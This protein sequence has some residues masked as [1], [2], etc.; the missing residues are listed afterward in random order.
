MTT[1]KVQTGVCNVPNRTIFEGDNLDVMRGMNDGCVD[2]IYLDPPFNSNRDYAAPIGSEA[3]GAAFKDTWGLTDVDEAWHNEIAETDLALYKIID[4]SQH[5][6]GSGMKSYLIMMAVRLIEMKRILKPTGSVYLHCDGTASHY[7]KALMDAV[8]GR[9]NFRNEIIWK[10]FNF[11]ADARRFGKV[12]DSLLFYSKTEKYVFNR[13]KAPY[14]KDYIESKFTHVDDNGRRFRL[15]NLNP[16]GGRGPVYEF[17]GVTK[18]WRYTEEN[19]RA[20]ESE[21]RIYTKS[22]VAQLKRYLDELDGQA[23]HNMWTDVS[24]INPRAKERTGYP[25]QKPLAL[26]DRIIKASSNEG[27]VV[28]DPFCGCATTCI[29]AERLDRRWIGIDLSALAV[30]L[31]EQRARNEL[32]LMGGVQAIARSGIPLRTDRK[33]A[34]QLSESKVVLYGTQGGNC[35]GCGTHFLPQHLTVD[36]II[37][38]SKGGT[39]HL[40]NLQL[41]CGHCN[42]L[43]GNR[44]MEYLRARLARGYA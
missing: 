40:D 16:P 21:G 4:A 26:L 41:L 29:A 23:V 2:L 19:M 15:D 27:D 14:S 10:R 33:P 28:L 44:P 11:H 6:H 34:P 43:K 17:N 25:T 36:H 30:K 35:N 31:V 24:P 20:L 37:A 13:Q 22:N 9:D 18:A 12:S 5:S 8:F 42:S 7:L 1:S 32:G 3:A 39:G 38:R